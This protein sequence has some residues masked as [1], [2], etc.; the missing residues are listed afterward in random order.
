MDEQTVVHIGENSPE[1]VA[2]RLMQDVLTVE[3]KEVIGRDPSGGRE[4]ATR[5]EIL[6]I[7]A[8]CLHTIR[9]PKARQ[10]T[11]G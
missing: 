6:D 1:H 2:Y 4:I 11:D 10:S 9:Y 3:N 8:E 5:K 7:Y